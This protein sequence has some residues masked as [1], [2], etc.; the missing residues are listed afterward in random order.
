MRCFR[1]RWRGGRFG[2]MCTKQLASD[3]AHFPLN[4]TVIYT[5]MRCAH[6]VRSLQ[7]PRGNF[8]VVLHMRCALGGPR[9]Q[10]MAHLRVS[11]NDV[12]LGACTS[13]VFLSTMRRAA[14]RD[15]KDAETIF[16]P[17][18]HKRTHTH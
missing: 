17:P 7:L 16:C 3:H 9:F 5:F 1:R 10:L 12:I 11:R 18:T 13:A 8:A 15:F 14:H 4:S 2:T 6:C